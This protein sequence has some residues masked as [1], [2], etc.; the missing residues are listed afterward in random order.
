MACVEGLDARSRN[1]VSRTGTGAHFQPK[2]AEFRAALVRYFARRLREPE[3]AEDLA[4]EVLLRLFRRGTIND[5]QALQCYVFET[6]NSVLVDWTRRN[7]ARSRGAH[8]PIDADIVDPRVFPCDRIL[9]SR[10]EVSRV[11]AS[12]Q[13]LPER[14]RTIFILRRLEGM[15]HGDIATRLGVSL[16]TV[17]KHVHRA[18]AHL[19]E[20]AD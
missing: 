12:L 8:Q 11:A 15:K 1:C 6:A 2:A 10:Q 5:M 7:K 17:E 16:S 18:A 14:T 19:L 9:E 20:S 3:E 4:H 13:E